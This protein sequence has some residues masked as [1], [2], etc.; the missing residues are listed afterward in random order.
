MAEL[1]HITSG[2]RTSMQ[3][4]PD[5][6]DPVPVELAL[7]APLPSAPLCGVRYAAP[8]TSGTFA[9]S[10]DDLV[11][12]L[13]VEAEVLRAVAHLTPRRAHELL[14]RIA[15]R[16]RRLEVPLAGTSAEPQELADPPKVVVSEVVETETPKPDEKPEPIWFVPKAE[17]PS[18]EVDATP[19]LRS[20]LRY[21]IAPPQNKAISQRPNKTQTILNV[22]AT[23][24]P[25]TRHQLYLE[26]QKLKLFGESFPVVKARTSSLLWQLMAKDHV[27]ESP[28]GW[29]RISI[30]SI[31]RTS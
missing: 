28:G 9:L 23:K 10:I 3:V 13:E 25:I 5:W 30:G 6:C 16:L 29:L 2:C 8:F 15:L 31:R 20:A 26:M 4:H 14:L 24:E 22:I 18:V 12:E 1:K 11:H 19:P 7:T 21:L 27:E 17:P